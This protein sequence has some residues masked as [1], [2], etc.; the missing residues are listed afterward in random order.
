MNHR[1]PVA[2]PS[3]CWMMT[4]EYPPEATTEYRKAIR[5]DRKLMAV[6]HLSSEM[7]PED[8]R[9]VSLPPEK[10]KSP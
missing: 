7:V 3:S 9:P 5:L 2:A 4:T 6:Y 10:V 8:H 1:F